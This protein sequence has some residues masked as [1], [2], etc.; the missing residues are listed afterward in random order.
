MKSAGD[1]LIQRLASTQGP[2]LVMMHPYYALLAG[3]EK[4]VDIQMLWHARLRGEEPL[5]DDFVSKIQNHYYST[6]VSDESTFETQADIHQLI[7]KYYLEAEVLTPSQA[8]LTNTGVVV[9][10]KIIY[11]PKQP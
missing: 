9:R 4:A 11:V 8:P 1:Q 5:P 10:P 7:T 6:I 3:K 2:V